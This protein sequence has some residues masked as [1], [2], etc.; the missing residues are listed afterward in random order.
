MLINAKSSQKLLLSILAL[1]SLGACSGGDGSN[2]TNGVDGANGANALIAQTELSDTDERCSAGGFVTESGV[3]SNQNGALDDDEIE[4]TSVTCNGEDGADDATTPGSASYKMP[5][6]ILVI[7]D[8]VGVDQF[9]SFGFGGADAPPVPTLDSLAGSGVSFANTWS[10]PT[11][12]ASRVSLFSGRYPTRTSTNT[13][14]VST[15]LANSQ[16]SPYERSL[17]KVLA[18]SGYASAYVG[19]IHASG[20]SVNPA[21]FPMGNETIAKLGW[22][23]F[24]GYLDGGPRPIDASAGLSNLDASTEPYTCGFIP[25]SDQHPQGADT[26]ACYTADG[27]CEVL[28][29]GGASS[30][31]KVCLDRGGILDPNNACESEA[32]SRI[33]FSR[34]N[35]YYTAELIVN[36]ALGAKAIPVTDS[37]TRLHRTKLETDLAIDW[38]QSRTGRQPWMMTVGYSAAHAPL[39]PVPDDL[40]PGATP[41]PSGTTCTGTRDIRA[42]MNQNLTAIDA[43]VGRLLTTVGVMNIADDGQMAYDAASNTVVAFIG[44]NGSLGT[45]VKAPFVPSRA[46][47]TIYQGGVWVPMIVAGPYV[48]EPGRVVNEMTNIIDLYHLFAV[49]GEHEL[50]APEHLRLDIR[51]LFPYMIEEN[52][53]PQRR[54]NFTYSGRNIQNQTPDPCILPDLNICLQLFPQEAVCKSEGGDW[55]GEGGVVEGQSFSSCCAVNDYFVITGQPTVDILAETQAAIRNDSF[56]LLKFEEPNCDAG[57]AL[58]PRLEM[59]ALS[60]GAASPEGNLDNLAASD[61]LARGDGELNAVQQTN[62]EQLTLQMDKALAGEPECTGDGNMDYVIDDKDLDAWAFWQEETSGQSSWYDINLDGLTDEADQQIILDNMGVTCVLP[63]QDFHPGGDYD[64]YS[65][66][67][68][69]DGDHHDGG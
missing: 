45:T 14:I 10:N 46:K 26:G 15:D 19:K 31:G 34:S 38:I 66:S 13:A 22:D 12:S 32:P 42:L 16:M 5:N 54:F 47:A 55:Y 52:P 6:I 4:N 20:S 21:N 64:F 36:D 40:I 56:K 11:C 44:D 9:R 33:D 48:V 3:D 29:D 24:A 62:Y 49:L 61:L 51:H 2:G 69:H 58:E 1:L 7:A 30:V 35:A 39:Q 68:D 18:R 8:D 37:R 57:G 59:Y 53:K 28:A 67:H 43:E 63:E 65:D 25:S 27:A 60:A 17:P 41:L 23:Y 50:T